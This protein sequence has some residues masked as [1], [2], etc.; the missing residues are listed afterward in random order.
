MDDIKTIVLPE[1]PALKSNEELMLFWSKE[2][3]SILSSDEVYLVKVTFNYETKK[4]FLDM[5]RRIPENK[6]TFTINKACSLRISKKSELVNCIPKTYSSLVV[7]VTEKEEHS[8]L[9]MNP[10][11]NKMRV[12]AQCTFFQ[13]KM[14][15]IIDILFKDIISI[16]FKKVTD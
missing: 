11:K 6:K 16:E 9:S 2:I 12:N 5:F 4:T 15:N 13:G 1:S 14:R 10:F 7:A 3:E 8:F